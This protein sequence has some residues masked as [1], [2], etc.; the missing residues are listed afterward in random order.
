M[1]EELP[2]C[3][4]V[5]TILNKDQ[6]YYLKKKM[7]GLEQGDKTDKIKEIALERRLKQWRVWGLK[8]Y[9]DKNN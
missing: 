8:E 3:R 6:V 5:A 9:R 7:Q 1:E 4:S 2:Q